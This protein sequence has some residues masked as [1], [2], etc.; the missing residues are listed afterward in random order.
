MTEKSHVSM[1]A[2]VCLVCCEEFPDGTV[3][4]DR[5][6]RP[7]FNRITVTGW[8]ICPDHAKQLD[9]GKNVALVEIDP[10]R[11]PAKP[12][13]TVDPTQ[14][15]RTGLT[16]LIDRAAF[17]E[18]LTGCDPIPESQPVVFV[19]EGMFEK[20]LGKDGLAHF[21]KDSKGPPPLQNAPTTESVN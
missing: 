7:K 9:N 16:M 19:Q 13:G 11:S 1:G 18:G 5:Q 8:G 12:D 10:V 21:L 3:L 20:M 17:N 14:A 6:L 4:L 2:K 15:Y